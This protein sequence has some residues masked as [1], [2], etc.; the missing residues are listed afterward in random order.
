MYS[1]F[2]EKEKKKQRLG[3]QNKGLNWNWKRRGVDEVV[4][5]AVCKCENAVF[6][7]RNFGYYSN[8]VRL[9]PNYFQSL[10]SKL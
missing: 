1:F 10:Q 4:P 7:S 5:P 3:D 9:I 6:H 2:L 8:L